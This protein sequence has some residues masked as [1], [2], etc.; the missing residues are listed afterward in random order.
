MSQ[1]KILTCS[2]KAVF[3]NLSEAEGFQQSLTAMFLFLPDR[4][5]CDAEIRNSNLLIWGG[6]IVKKT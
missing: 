2:I 5:S 4:I 6:L 1:L 3:I